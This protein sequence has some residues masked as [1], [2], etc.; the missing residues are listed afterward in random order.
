MKIRTLWGFEGN[1]A[2]LG[3]DSDRVRAGVVFDEAEDEYA[4]V[5]IGKGLAEEVDGK[6]APKTNKQAKPEENK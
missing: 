3:T 6:T 2:K 1:A 5:L 4:H